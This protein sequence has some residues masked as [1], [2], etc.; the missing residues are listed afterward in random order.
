VSQENVGIVRAAI[1][2]YNETGELPWDL[3]DPDVEWV[4]DPS[5]NLAGPYHGHDGVSLYL[6]QLHDALDRLRLEIDEFVDAGDSVV[7]L[8]RMRVHGKRSDV[9]V[10]QQMALLCRVWN[11][12]ILTLR[13][14]IRQAEALE[15]AGLRE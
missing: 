11:G 1:D 7:A 3:I 8:G 14:Y 6:K 13:T 10:E 12:R 9:T 15:A 2:G 4:I 5:G